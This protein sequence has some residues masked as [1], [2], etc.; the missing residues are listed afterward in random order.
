MANKMPIPKACHVHD[1]LET[2]T[3]DRVTAVHDVLLAQGTLN[4]GL[5]IHDQR[6]LRV[7]HI[8][9]FSRRRDSSCRHPR[10]LS[11]QRLRC[12]SLLGLFLYRTNLTCILYSPNAM[13]S[14]GGLECLPNLHIF[15]DHI[16]L[17]HGTPAMR[18]QSFDKLGLVVSWFRKRQQFFVTW[19][20]CFGLGHL[21]RECC[22]LLREGLQRCG[23]SRL[24]CHFLVRAEL[25]SKLLT[26]VTGQSDS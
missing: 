15:V 17:R 20:V 23:C 12:R 4:V 8:S 7:C 24:L 9:H 3:L 1:R 21:R 10:G 6:C 14:H 16:S 13:K 25:P 26:I 19:Y 2:T 5:N 11:Q 18:L 22:Y